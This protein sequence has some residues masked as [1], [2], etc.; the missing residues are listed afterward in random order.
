M[1]IPRVAAVLLLSLFCLFCVATLAA[2]A[3]PDSNFVAS[4]PTTRGLENPFRDAPV[5]PFNMQMISATKGKSENPLVDLSSGVGE[6]EAVFF[7]TP[8]VDFAPQ[9]D[10]TCLSMRTYRVKRENPHSD[11]VRPAGYSTC[12]PTKRFQLKSAVGESE[13][14]PR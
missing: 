14:V 2:Q 9:A 1:S 7:W 6:K 12:Q 5:N 8:P 11:A 3:S 10:V 13:V 4:P